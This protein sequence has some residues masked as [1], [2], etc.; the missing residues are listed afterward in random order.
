M[1]PVR[2]GALLMPYITWAGSNHPRKWWKNPNPVT[3]E[4]QDDFNQQI[5]NY[6][7]FLR[8]TMGMINLAAEG[9]TTLNP[10]HRTA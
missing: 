3:E 4:R 6:I 2:S 8:G 1:Q 9:L 10:G 7:K 5:A